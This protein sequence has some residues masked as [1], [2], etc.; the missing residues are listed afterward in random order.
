[1]AAS[2]VW[3]M[4]TKLNVNPFQAV[5][6]LPLVELVQYTTTLRRPLGATS[7]GGKTGDECRRSKYTN[8]GGI[9]GTSNFVRGSVNFVQRDVEASSG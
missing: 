1:M 8:Y 6:S 4:V 5:N 7:G 3:R 9:H 2:C